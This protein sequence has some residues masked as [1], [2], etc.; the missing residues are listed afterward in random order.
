MTRLNRYLV[1][2]EDTNRR[3]VKDPP[4]TLLYALYTQAGGSRTVA[5]RSL[6]VCMHTFLR[7]C[8]SVTARPIASFAA[9]QWAPQLSLQPPA[10]S[11]ALF[12]HWCI[13]QSVTV[14]IWTPAIFFM[15]ERCAFGAV[16]SWPAADGSL[17][18][19]VGLLKASAAAASEWLLKEELHSAAAFERGVCATVASQNVGEKNQSA[20]RSTFSFSFPPLCRSN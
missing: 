10:W 5:S 13:P 17:E 15:E 16:Q 14:R 19:R 20:N 1:G 11:L 9:P 8:L 3:R 4:A 2:T 18:K 12:M 7:H 6:E